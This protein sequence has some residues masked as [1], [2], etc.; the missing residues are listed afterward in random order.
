MAKQPKMR[1]SPERDVPN[2]MHDPFDRIRIPAQMEDRESRVK[3]L[4]ESAEKLKDGSLPSRKA[5]LFLGGA[6]DAWLAEGGDLAR[7]YL[8]I[9]APRGSHRKAQVIVAELRDRATTAS[10]CASSTM[11]TRKRRLR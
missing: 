6:L 5:C 10:K 11:R 8:K 3:M 4:L 7:D 1:R 2:V 9:Q